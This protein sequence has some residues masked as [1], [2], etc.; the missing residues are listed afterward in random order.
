M[1]YPLW[2][3]VRFAAVGVFL[4]RVFA[5]SPEDVAKLPPAAN[6]A[7]DFARDIKPIFEASCTKCHGRGRDKGKFNLDTFDHLMVGG[8][9]G[10]PLVK[11]SSVDSLLIELVAGI[12]PD[13]V[14]PQKG[15]RLTPEQVGTLRAWIDQGAV[16]SPSISLGRP[17]PANLEPT[18]PALPGG[19]SAR[20][21]IDRILAPYFQQHGV[22]KTRL[23]SD[24]V[25]ARRVWLDT[26]GLLPSP[27][28]LRAF[29]RDRN[30]QKRPELVHRLLSN[31]TD[32]AIHWLSF[33]NDLLR[34]DYRGTGYID[35]GRKA[36]TPWLL[37]SLEHNKPYQ[38]FAAEL[39]NP[40]PECEGFVRGIVWRG[41]VNASMSPP[42]QAA[43]NLSQVFMGTNLKCASCHD[44]FV[45]DWTLADSYGLAGI[46]SETPL[47]MSECDKPT[48]KTARPKFLYEKLG[49]ID[50]HASRAERLSRLADLIT[51]RSNGRFTRTVVNRLWARFFG[52][53]IVEPVDVMEK[54][55]WN[56]GLLG[57]LAE[58]LANHDYD[59]KHTMEVMLTSEA[60][61]RPA[62][63]STPTSSKDF[64][65]AGPLVRRMTAEQFSD[66]IS[67]VT[68]RWNAQP[69]DG[70]V[71]N[72]WG[73][74]TFPVVR[75]GL[76]P[77]S[78]LQTAMGRPNR[79]QVVTVRNSIATT[80][81]AL[82]L[83]NGSEV[84]SRLHEA[85]VA[86]LR[87]EPQ[88]TAKAVVIEVYLKA[89][90]RK[91]SRSELSLAKKLVG[92]PV[93]TEGLEDFLWAV[94][95]LPEFQL[96]Q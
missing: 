21:P 14:M 2:I 3:L 43:Q 67:A 50:P 91:P 89:L 40:S 61:Q 28:E 39:V 44:S 85:A 86:R 74:Q 59:L 64:V 36:I 92:S 13:Y 35:G 1:P 53:G 96:I 33:W 5:L 7:I 80:L 10:A 56:Q 45:D 93:N 42:M 6:R 54:S 8:D 63:V 26:I 65:F 95:M 94:V 55:G 23:V 30:P 70:I 81:E 31:S 66:A 84:T 9:S 58:N 17:P 29:E 47:Q 52:Y 79:E 46:Y 19:D 38:R 60:Y 34:N 69:D 72:H 78:P 57:W 68:G 27:E 82:E 25:Y 73:G 77:A 41:V 12:D 16:W 22:Q 88:P 83:T 48:G 20:N 71:S 49:S 51:G 18:A 24:A 15:K 62:V 87:A 4:P 90:G 11:G 76:I 32:Y 75:A 37:T